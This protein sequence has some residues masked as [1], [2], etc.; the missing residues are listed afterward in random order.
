MVAAKV[1]GENF[2]HFDSLFYNDQINKIIQH[3]LPRFDRATKRGVRLHLFFLSVISAEF[4]LF[5]VLLGFLIES[6]LVAV[7]L[8]LIFLTVFSYLALRL[9]V[10]EQ[11]P[12]HLD[13]VLNRYIKSCKHLLNYSE[14][15]PEHLVELANALGK[16]S[17]RLNGREYSYWK[18]P[19]FMPSLAPFFE[20]FSLFWH[21]KDVLMMRELLLKASVDEHIKLVRMEPTSLEVHAGLANAYVMLSQIYQYPQTMEG[22]WMGEESFSQELEDN[23]RMTAERAVEEFKI[24]EEYAPQDPW[25]HAQLAYSYNDLKM[26]WEEIR[27]Y[28]EICRLAPHD[29]DALFRLGVLYFKQGQNALGLKIYEDLRKYH[30]TKAEQL[31]KHYGNY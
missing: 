18:A 23:Y 4:F 20:R 5:L 21:H 8:S 16:F 11:K 17:G 30:Y 7:A 10:I 26:P 25:V 28:E 2:R 27:E 31:I 14:E 1:D 24:L 6:S 19:R 15:I 29:K 13:D 3:I 9:W 22:S 12:K